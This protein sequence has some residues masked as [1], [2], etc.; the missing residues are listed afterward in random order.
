MGKKQH[1]GTVYRGERLERVAF[2]LGGL[3]AGMICLEGAGALSHVSLRHRPEI[4][5]EPLVFAAL[6]VKGARPAR[7]LEGPVPRWK[8]AHPWGSGFGGAGNGLGGKDYGL[9]RFS[10][11]RF[12]ARFPFGRVELRDAAMPVRAA[13]CGWSPFLPGNADDSGLPVAALEYSFRNPARRPRDCV[14][15]FHAANFMRLAGLKPEEESA[16]VRP[17]EGGF[18]LEQ[19]AVEGLPASAGVFAAWVPDGGAVSDCA[20]FRGKWFDTLTTLWGH[21]AAGDV[22]SRPP[23]AVGKPGGGGSIYLPFRLPPGGTRTIELLFAWHVPRS[24]LRTGPADDAPAAADAA[25]R[26]YVPWYA[27]RFADVGEVVETWQERYDLLREETLRFSDCFHDTT[28]PPEAVEAVAAN[29]TI[30]KS[31]TCLRQHDGRFWAWE[32][33]CDCGGCCAGTCT[34]VWNYAQALPHLF[35]SLERGLRETEFLVSQDARGHQN[36]R[37]ALP[38]RPT[39]HGFHAA[40]DGQLG[41]LVKLYREWRISGDTAWMRELWPRARAS[42]DYCIA[43]WDPGRAGL[44]A[45]PHHNTYDIEFWGPDALCGGFYLSALQAAILMGR[46]CGQDVS[47]Y[48]ELLARGRARMESELWNGAYF[49]QRVQWRELRATPPWQTPGGRADHSPEELALLEREGPKYQYGSGC[50]ADGVL[51]DWLA[52]VSGLPAV[53]D[54]RKVAR[55]LAAVHRHNFREDLSGHANPQRPAYALGDEAGLLLC[56]WPRGGRPSLPFPYCDEVWTGFEYHVAAH[57]I[58]TGRKEKGL[59]IVRAARSRYDG[60]R[61]NPFNEIECGHWYARAMSSYSLLQALSGARY[62]AVERKLHL[63]PALKGDFRAFL[64]TASGYGTVGVKGGRPFFEARSGHVPVDEIVF[65]PA[66]PRS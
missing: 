55:H 4:F 2:P 15:S 37:S 16:R 53:L 66:S 14:F 59:E 20:W 57:L 43:T 63:A 10:S 26:H 17:L 54:P 42:L 61:R 22:V 13:I 8:I 18:L 19:P 41:G 28:L 32:G 33:C 44:P 64:C 31:P 5:N 60:R 29:L 21:V 1:R 65:T 52:R 45:E 24:D 46:A 7:L 49:F 58:M 34:H 12:Q 9:P 3:G 39:D 47:A 23:H 48:E 35:P 62:D 51:G 27:T 36:F 6:H 11:C 30:L 40:A 56:T 25:P 50:L 38:I